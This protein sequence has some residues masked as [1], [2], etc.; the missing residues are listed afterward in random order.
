MATKKPVAIYYNG[1]IW[2]AHDPPG[3]GQLDGVAALSAN[4]VWASGTSLVA[5]AKNVTFRWTGSAW[6][7]VAP[8]GLADGW[9]ESMTRVPGST[10]LWAV[11]MGISA[12][13]NSG[14]PFAAY[15]H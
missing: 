14:G 11:G 12:A 13:G 15:Y 8:A 4:D 1:T 3:A 6:H 9:V 10:Q 5:P 2:K 7:A